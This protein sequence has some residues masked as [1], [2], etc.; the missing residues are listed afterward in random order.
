MRNGQ[1][2]FCGVIPFTQE[3]AFVAANC[4]GPEAT[5]NDITTGYQVMLSGPGYETPRPIGITGVA[6]N[7]HYN[8]STFA[9]NIAILTLDN[10]G[11]QTTTLETKIGD[12]PSEWPYY[13]FVQHSLTENLGQ[14]NSIGTAGSSPTVNFNPCTESSSLF[15]A[16]KEA[17]ICSTLLRRS[18][19]HLECNT[20][21]KYVVGSDSLNNSAIIAL[22]SYSSIPSTA[23]NGFC[24]NDGGIMNFYTNLMNYIP[25]AERVVNESIQRFHTSTNNYKETSDADYSMVMPGPKAE[26]NGAQIYG[27]YGIDQSILGL[28]SLN[29]KKSTNVENTAGS[30]ADEN[31]GNKSCS[32]ASMLTVTEYQTAPSDNANYGTVADGSVYLSETTDPLGNIKTYTFT[33]GPQ[34][35][36]PSG[37]GDKNSN[38]NVATTTVYVGMAAITATDNL[39]STLDNEDAG[40]AEASTDSDPTS[41]ESNGGDKRSGGLSHGAAIAIVVVTMAAV[42]LAGLGYYVLR[43]RR[44]QKAQRELEQAD[45]IGPALGQTQIQIQAP[46]QP[47]HTRYNFTS[48]IF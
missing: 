48:Y 27:F 12:L 10:A 11:G 29:D 3:H 19:I 26:N 40:D 2:T 7:K 47:Y 14:W 13:Y 44:K 5:E 33:R 35:T 36:N 41:D 28:D 31:G 18:F 46:Q 17:L 8:N 23:F 39:H 6:I 38:C 37:T 22:Y 43:R 24:S 4:F 15:G 42:V 34:P 20:P 25:W 16:N 30:Q 45:N 1:Q 9:N 21:Y 32:I